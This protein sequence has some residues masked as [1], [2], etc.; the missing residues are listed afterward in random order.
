MR[1]IK[2]L[3]RSAL[4]VLRRL[5]GLLQTGLLALDDAGVTREQPG[6]LERGAVGL[7]VDR[8]EAP[9]HTEA[10]RAGLAGD[11]AAVDAGDDVEA[12]LELEGAERLVHD[13]LVQLVGEVGV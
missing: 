1:G 9:G 3:L 10:Q 13:L 12:A 2:A 5:A 8:V 7:L 6:L 4:R 11:A